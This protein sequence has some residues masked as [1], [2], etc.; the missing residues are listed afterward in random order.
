MRP[1][2]VIFL[3][4]GYP[5]AALMAA[6][7]P[8]FVIA[9][10]RESDLVE[11]VRALVEESPPATVVF[12]GGHLAVGFASYVLAR[13]RAAWGAAAG[14]VGALLVNAATAAIPL[15]QGARESGLFGP[16]LVAITFGVLAI[17]LGATV[18]PWVARRWP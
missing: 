2:V 6:V 17:V 10:S 4:L 13:R 18:P 7:L 5:L 8:F 15:N 16:F 3:A 11:F 12:L 14:A 1:G 9:V